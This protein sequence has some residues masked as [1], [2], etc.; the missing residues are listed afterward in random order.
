MLNDLDEQKSGQGS[1]SNGDATQKGRANKPAF[2]LT[3]L[4]ALV[5]VAASYY[6]WTLN[7]KIEALTE[8]TQKTEVAHKHQVK[9]LEQ[10]I[11][12]LKQQ[13]AQL[14]AD[15]QKLQLENQM[16]KDQL[17]TQ[18]KAEEKPVEVA[19]QPVA[20][21]SKPK[22]KA[23]PKKK[24]TSSLAKK[25]EPKIAVTIHKLT[26]EE[27][28]QRKLISAEQA[29]DKND[30]QSAE[31]YLAE[32]LVL[33]PDNKEARMKLATL[34]FAR[35]A[36]SAA[37]STLAQGIAI[38]FTDKDYRMLKARV[39]MK[40]GNFEAAYDTLAPLED[41]TKQ[42]YQVL[43]ANVAQGISKYDKAALAFQRLISMQPEAGR[44]YLG[45]ATAQDQMGQ[46]EAAVKSY[47]Q[48]LDMGNLAKPSADFVKQRLVALGE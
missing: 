39:Y 28:A 9:Q 35:G 43:L 27:L 6:I 10:E 41:I 12:S 40:Q 30:M 24:V 13:L 29:L 31:K 7:N 32:A 5:I 33:T 16:L 14:Q 4:L 26:P 47:K 36:N 38:D 17:A 37:H 42:D 46:F 44:W 8:Q 23:K 15:N 22:P 3:I 19:Q 2:F 25:E 1:S 11:A 18:P 48:A 20:P 21:V 34:Y 45:L